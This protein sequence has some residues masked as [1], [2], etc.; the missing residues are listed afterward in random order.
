VVPIKLE[1]KEPIPDP[2]LTGAPPVP[3]YAFKPKG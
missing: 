2:K 3:E 1:Y